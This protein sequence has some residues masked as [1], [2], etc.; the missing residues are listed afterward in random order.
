[1]P[2]IEDFLNMT[3]LNEREEDRRDLERKAAAL[4]DII[5]LYREHG[6]ADSVILLPTA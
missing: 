1:M 4:D 6:P 2:E 3:R 5:L